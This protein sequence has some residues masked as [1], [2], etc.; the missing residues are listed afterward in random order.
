MKFP[1]PP[2][3][4]IPGLTH[5]ASDRELVD[6]ASAFVAGEVLLRFADRLAS[7][8]SCVYRIDKPPA[9]VVLNFRLSRVPNWEIELV[10][11][12]DNQAIPETLRRPLINWCSVKGIQ[13]SPSAWEVSHD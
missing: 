13:S 7:G 11:A 10:L 2:Y 9:A 3:A 4:S 8:Q 5:I 1:P 6:L 12:Q